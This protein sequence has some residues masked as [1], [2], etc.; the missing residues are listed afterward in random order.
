[1]LAPQR[2]RTSGRHRP[3]PRRNP[4]STRPAPP[5]SR[6]QTTTPTLR[7]RTA[8]RPGRGTRLPSRQARRSRACS[9]ARGTAGARRDAAARLPPRR[10]SCGCRRSSPEPSRRRSLPPR[11]R[12]ACPAASPAGSPDRP[13]GR[14][15]TG[16]TPAVNATPRTPSLASP[17]RKSSALR[18]AAPV[19][20]RTA[21]DSS[22][23]AHV[24]PAAVSNPAALIRCRASTPASYH[25]PL[26]AE[27]QPLQPA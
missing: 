6:R 8:R 26:P 9:R 1:M 11:T 2:R 14:A 18:R 19:P 24:S 21:D 23:I 25:E 17:W 3:G 5:S 12:T 20:L 27:T 16:P 13:R 7:C 4:P 15:S 22:F 10:R